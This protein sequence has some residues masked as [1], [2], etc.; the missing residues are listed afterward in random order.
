MKVVTKKYEHL[1]FTVGFMEMY[2][3][4]YWYEP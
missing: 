2:I 3:K 1:P 4:N